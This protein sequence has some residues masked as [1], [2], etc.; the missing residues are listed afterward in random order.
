M[1]ELE[2]IVAVPFRK[3]AASA[4]TENEFV[5]ALS[6]D[7]K[8]FSPE[9]AKVVI[10]N[11]EKEGLLRREGGN[12]LPG[13]DTGTVDIPIGFRPEAWV[14]EKKSS[15][16]RIVDRIASG[17]KMER[18]KVVALINRKLEQLSRLVEIEAAAVIVARESDIEVN[19]LIDD[20]YASICRRGS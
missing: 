15:F 17:R 13:F 18:Q 2:R 6:L 11:A 19:D 8:W 4:L 14:F 5:L 1:S 9:Q 12:L 10:L 20:A 16:E 3:K 7:L